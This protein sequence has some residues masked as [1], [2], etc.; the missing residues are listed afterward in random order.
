[1]D[2]IPTHLGESAHADLS[3]VFLGGTMHTVVVVLHG[4]FGKHGEA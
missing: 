1:M 4:F 3:P 2:V